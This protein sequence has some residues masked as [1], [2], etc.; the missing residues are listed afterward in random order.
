MRIGIGYDIHRL[1]EGRRLMIGGVR[2]PHDKGLEGHSDGDSLIHAIVDALL[3]PTGM[4]DIGSHFA[5]TLPEWKDAPSIE[6]LRR[7]T[8]LLAERNWSI[9]NVD[10]TIVA[11]QPM[12]GRFIQAMRGKLATGMDI[13]VEQVTI[14]ATTTEGLSPDA[15][16]AWAVALLQEPG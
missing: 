8:A 10:S 3:S 14:Q 5:P 9:V 6:F 2:I 13:K 4:G 15:I 1:T 16:A 7:V 12:M 11:D